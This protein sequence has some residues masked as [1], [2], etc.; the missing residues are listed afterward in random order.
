VATTLVLLMALPTAGIGEL[1]YAC[2][3]T[4]N[5]GPR[6]CCSI[7]AKGQTP[8]DLD[9]S[10]GSCCEIVPEEGLVQATWFES[11]SQKIEPPQEA[12]A[13]RVSFPKATPH[14]LS[15]S[16]ILRQPRAPPPDL[17]TPLFRQHCTYLI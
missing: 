10:T 8:G 17:K 16:R 12:D 11:V 4:G 5:I 9:I 13:L 2:G 6:C 14:P 15:H 1:L 3:M 7:D